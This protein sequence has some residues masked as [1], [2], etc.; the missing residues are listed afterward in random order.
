M[1][2]LGIC[3]GCGRKSITKLEVTNIINTTIKTANTTIN[4][5]VNQTINEVSTE[6]INNVSSSII[7]DTNAYNKL[8]LSGLIL[9]G[10]T[11][12][13]NQQAKVDSQSI[14]M[15]NIASSQQSMDQLTTNLMN[16]LQQKAQTD[17]QLQAAMTQLNQINDMTKNA[18]GPEKVVDSVMGALKDTISGGGDK[19]ED[20]KTFLSKIGISADTE[21]TMKNSIS[22]MIKN[23]VSGK[24]T[25]NTFGSVKI[26]TAGGNTASIRNVTANGAIVNINQ[27]ATLY[28]FT[29]AISDLKIGSGIS[30]QILN[31]T[32]SET[33]TDILNKQAT[34]LKSKN[35]TTA[36]KLDD[37]ESGLTDLLKSLNPF[38]FLDSL[39]NKVKT[40]IIIVIVVFAGLLFMFFGLPHIIKL[41][42]KSPAP[43]TAVSVA[44]VTPS[45]ISVSKRKM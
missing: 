31:T 45:S 3:C 2:F 38:S 37:Q 18:G 8:D 21:N 36:V 34:D 39:G 28:N 20:E 30:N 14:A 27:N 40:I 43:V 11:F 15:N 17:T 33:M 41:F 10:G 19:K 4:N 22:N 6:L 9:T 23:S 32:T 7:V 1:C 44:P 25:S 16:S 24:I 35:D 13:V 29:K 26:G 42:K 12:D 5:I